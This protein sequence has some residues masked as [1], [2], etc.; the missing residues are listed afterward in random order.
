MLPPT[1]PPVELAVDNL[2]PSIVIERT[3]F[4]IVGIAPPGFFG[5]AVGTA[6]EITIPLTT[7]PLLRAED[8]DVLSQAGRAWLHIIGDCGPG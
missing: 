3:P 7:L 6:P 1:S 8:R 4:T 5:V 2:R